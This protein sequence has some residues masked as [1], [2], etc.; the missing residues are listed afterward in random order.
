MIQGLLPRLGL[1]DVDVL[2][3]NF[4]PVH[5]EGLCHPEIDVGDQDLRCNGDREIDSR[6][7]PQAAV[8]KGHK[9][10]RTVL[11]ADRGLPAGNAEARLHDRLADHLHGLF[12]IGVVADIE[13]EF[14][15]TDIGLVAEVFQTHGIQLTVGNDQPLRVND[16]DH[17]V[18]HGEVFHDARRAVLQFDPVAD[19]EGFVDTDHHASEDVLDGIL[20]GEGDHGTDD[21]SAAQQALPDAGR[22]AKDGEGQDTADDQDQG[23]VDPFQKKKVDAGLFLFDSFESEMIE[24]GKDPDQDQDDQKEN[25]LNREAVVPVKKIE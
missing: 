2:I 8:L 24:P 5:G 1:Q 16:A 10:Y 20:G 3:G 18:A 17:G 11:H 22:P 25:H 6:R 4:D 12:D 14:A 21:G 15:R 9:I 23:A 19:L 7:K 13:V